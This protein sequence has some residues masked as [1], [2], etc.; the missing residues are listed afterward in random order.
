LATIVAFASASHGRV[1]LGPIDVVVFAFYFE[2]VRLIGF[3]VKTR[4]KAGKKG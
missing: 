3:Y 1:H 2:P 4:A